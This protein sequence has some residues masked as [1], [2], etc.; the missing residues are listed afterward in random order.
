MSNDRGMIKW[1]PFNSVINSN[2][3][4][5]E[6]IKEREKISQPIIS[7]EDT[8]NIEDAIINAYYTK[9]KVKI[10]YYENGYLL[11]IISKIK[12]ID[13]IY[14][15]IYLDNKRLLFKQII[16]INYF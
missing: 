4:I 14:K 7:N 1:A 5:K 16:K 2:Q 10:I 9:S 6:L 8:K 12:K 15:M 11:N 3:I 13:Q